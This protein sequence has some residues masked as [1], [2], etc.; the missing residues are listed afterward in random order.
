M[1]LPPYVVPVLNPFWHGSAGFA[2]PGR[3]D[4]HPASADGAAP[5]DDD[6][7]HSP[8]LPIAAPASP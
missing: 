4:E 2:S 3:L 8:C 7:D 5:F 1:S 6:E